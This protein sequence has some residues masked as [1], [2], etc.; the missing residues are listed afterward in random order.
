MKLILGGGL[1]ALLTKD[2]LGP[3]WTIIPIGKSRHY[4]FNPP[5]TDNY[6]Q[7]DETILEYIKQFYV[8]PLLYRI[9]YSYAGHITFNHAVALNKY[10]TKLYDENVPPHAGA[11]WSSRTDHFGCGD[12][13][14]I[15]R[16]LNTKYESEI[17]A[18]NLKYGKPIKIKDN[19]LTTSTGSNLEYTQIVSTVPLYALLEWNGIS[20]LELPSKDIYYYH[21]RTN[22]I[23]FE[24]ATKLLV[25]D[26]EIDFHE[27]VMLNKENY[28][29]KSCKRI[30][31]P[32]RYFMQFMKKFELIAETSIEKSVCCG[33]IPNIPELKAANIVCIGKSA[34]WD[35]CLD[36]GSVCKRLIK[37]R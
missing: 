26:S 24:G 33:P 1:T 3:D 34:V 10:L 27:A 2:I 22:D 4:S 8:I 36:L 29:F 28:I 37:M 18:N 6:I 17:L 23:D 25:V 9:G 12:C 16:T 35:D 11:Y 30:E 19:V 20:G 31:Y 5:L 21:I 13:F 14:D 32:G 7:Q 15:Y